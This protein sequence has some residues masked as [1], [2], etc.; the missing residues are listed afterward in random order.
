[1]GRQSSTLSANRL[2]PERDSTGKKLSAM[3]DSLLISDI[4]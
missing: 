4:L 2:L 3:R 1:M